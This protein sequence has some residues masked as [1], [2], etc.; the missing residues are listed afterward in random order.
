MLSA[1]LLP[2]YSVALP[3]RRDARVIDTSG[4]KTLA[5]VTE[6]LFSRQKHVY[7][8]TIVGEK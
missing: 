5:L 6:E 2:T 8:F 3:D 4:G 7:V 1:K